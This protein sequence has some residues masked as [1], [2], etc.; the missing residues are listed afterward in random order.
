[1]IESPCGMGLSS[2]LAAFRVPL[3]TKEYE[4]VAKKMISGA[5][6]AAGTPVMSSR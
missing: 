2:D 4:T 1:M 5:S 6:Y 3:K